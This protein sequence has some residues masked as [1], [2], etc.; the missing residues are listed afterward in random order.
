MKKD[1]G[2][3]A[4]GRFLNNWDVVLEMRRP[5]IWVLPLL[6]KPNGT[7]VGFYRISLVSIE[8]NYQKHFW[9][10]ATSLDLPQVIDVIDG[11][12]VTRKHILSIHAWHKRTVVMRSNV[13]YREIVFA[14]FDVETAL[15]G[16]QQRVR[17]DVHIGENPSVELDMK[18]AKLSLQLTGFCIDRS[19]LSV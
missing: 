1:P 16:R 7:I 18:R 13:D 4:V 10:M 8:N 6:K 17:L 3:D 14:A 2:L 19:F 15:T 11:D 5:S 12:L 9:G